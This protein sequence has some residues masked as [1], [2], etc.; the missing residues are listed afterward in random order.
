MRNTVKKTCFLSIVV[1]CFDGMFWDLF[2]MMLMLL[3]Q[4]YYLRV[5]L[6]IYIHSLTCCDMMMKEVV[7]LCPVSDLQTMVVKLQPASRTSLPPYNPLLPPPAISQ[8]VL[9][10][11]PQKVPRNDNLSIN[12]VLVN[13]LLCCFFFHLFSDLLI[14]FK[15]SFYSV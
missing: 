1:P 10:A 15:Y 12:A 2:L 11:N 6:F 4:N 8:V 5:I 13:A 3:M 14:Y 9:L 7:F